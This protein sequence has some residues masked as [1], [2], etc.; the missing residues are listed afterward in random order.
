[1]KGDTIKIPTTWALRLGCVFLGA[2]G[3]SGA[4]AY[5]DGDPATSD[6]LSGDFVI[7]YEG[8]LKIDDAGA[9][10]SVRMRF[11]LFEI[12]AGPLGTNGTSPVWVEERDVDM[13]NGRFSVAL[14]ENT[15]LNPTVLDAQ[16]VGLKITLLEDDGQ[17]GTVEVALGGMQSIEAAPHVAW[18]G[19]AGNFDVAGA[20]NVV[21]DVLTQSTARVLGDLRVEGTELRLGT[22]NASGLGP[23]G[24]A[25]SHGA[26]DTLVLNEGGPFSGG[27]AVAGPE[28]S[29]SGDLSAPGSVQLGASGDDVHFLGALDLGGQLVMN[30]GTFDLGDGDVTGLSKLDPSDLR[31]SGSQPPSVTFGSKTLTI[32]TRL[33]AKGKVL[34]TS[35]S[36]FMRTFDRQP[37]TSGSSSFTT[38]VQ[39]NQGFCL[40]TRYTSSSTRNGAL[41]MECKAE[42]LNGNW[43]LLTS[44]PPATNGSTDEFTLC[45]FTCFELLPLL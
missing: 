31:G 15:R 5:A 14:G 20:L 6:V 29:V 2:L 37:G 3:Y 13:Y 39:E 7:P 16:K 26:G 18:T 19:N 10:G 27:V 41:P 44:G 21:R 32:P 12:K 30:G 23:G 1:M 34:V 4:L 35:G 22:S 45:Q 43:T 36:S 38:T 40:L 9:L 33:D 17:G 11:E 8:F 25:L 42:I 28:L 24:K